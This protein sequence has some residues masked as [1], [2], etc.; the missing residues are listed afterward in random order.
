MPKTEILVFPAKV[1]HSQASPSQLI[2][3]SDAPSGSPLRQSTKNSYRKTRVSWKGQPGEGR[4]WANQSG[5]HSNCL[6][7]TKRA[8]VI[9]KG[10]L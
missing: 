9:R 8:Q 4:K 3:V 10:D 5:L 7:R 1:L 2:L 6:E